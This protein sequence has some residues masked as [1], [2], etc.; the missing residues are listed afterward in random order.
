MAYISIMVSPILPTKSRNLNQRVEKFNSLLTMYMDSD[1]ASS[2]LRMVNLA[3]FVSNEGILNKEELGV[4]DKMNNIYS[5]H[6][7]LHLGKGGNCL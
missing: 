5:K 3:S 4:C 2:G 7:I 6:D 1:P